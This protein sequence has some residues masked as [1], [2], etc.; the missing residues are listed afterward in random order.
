METATRPLLTGGC[1]RALVEF[2]G[3]AVRIFYEVGSV[4]DAGGRIAGRGYTLGHLAAVGDHNRDSAKFA[5]AGF[6]FTFADDDQRVRPEISRHAE[7]ILD[8][9]ALGGDL[10]IDFQ[11]ENFCV[12]LFRAL[13]I[14]HADA[15]AGDADGLDVFG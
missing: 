14:A 4:N 5:G 1:C 2:D 13:E 11:A 7:K 6:D 9:L 15:E 3:V 10:G 8:W 12:E